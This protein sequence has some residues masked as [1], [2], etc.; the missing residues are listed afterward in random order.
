MKRSA[1]S[2]RRG[3]GGGLLRAAGLVAACSLPLAALDTD[4]QLTPAAKAALERATTWLAKAQ[5]PDGS[6]PGGMGL[7]GAAMLGL[8]ASGNIPGS[9]QHGPAVARGVAYICANAQP[10]G[11]LYKEKDGG[12][13]SNDRMYHHGLALLALAEVWGE[14]RDP[15]VRG[16]IK[17]AVDLIC[18]SQNQEGGWRYQPYPEQADISVTVM[19]LMALRAAKDAGLAVPKE[20]IEAGVQYVKACHNAK[21]KG[22]DGGF[23]YQKNGKGSGFARTGAG[24]TALQVA[25]NYRAQEVLEGVEYLTQHKPMGEKDQGGHK[26]YGIYYATIGLYQA[27]GIN[28]LCR[29]WWTRWYP[30]ATNYVISQQSGDG[31]F[32]G[33]ESGAYGAAMGTLVLALP[34]R[35]LPIYQR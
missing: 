24:V 28:P 4:E 7:T 19:Q 32:K 29:S 35:C 25:G 6:W 34:Y 13:S 27:Q 11:L 20:V 1:R 14:T 3:W 30:A 31:S 17:R 5:Q 26:A 15:R 16:V 10:K 18:S 8:M 23:S 2:H 12:K 9:G 22:Q 33:F 21:Q